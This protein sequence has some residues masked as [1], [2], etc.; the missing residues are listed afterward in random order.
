MATEAI[1]AS[2]VVTRAEKFARDLAQRLNELNDR[3]P[4][5]QLGPE[6]DWENAVRAQEFGE[7]VPSPTPN[8][9]LPAFQELFCRYMASQAE[10]VPDEKQ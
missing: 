5:P 9:L 7:P 2:E 8:D 3:C 6:E 4:S 10:I 1:K